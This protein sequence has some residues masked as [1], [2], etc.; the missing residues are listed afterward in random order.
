M[1][2]RLTLLKEQEFK[3]IFYLL[4]RELRMSDI[5][6]VCGSDRLKCP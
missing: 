5:A 4:M 6:I 2:Q 3:L 1:S